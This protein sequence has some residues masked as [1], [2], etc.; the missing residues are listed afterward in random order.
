MSTGVF[1]NGIDRYLGFWNRGI[2]SM[3]SCTTKRCSLRRTRHCSLLFDNAATPTRFW[4]VIWPVQHVRDFWAPGFYWRLALLCRL[5]FVEEMSKRSA[6]SKFGCDVRHE[7]GVW[8]FLRD[9]LKLLGCSWLRLLHR[10][11]F[12][13]F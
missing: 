5:L 12:V 2:S 13:Y 3:T 7:G 9:I 11:E 10:M 8:L 6:W 4:K 1:S